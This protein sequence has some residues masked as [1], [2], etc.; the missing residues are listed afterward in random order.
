MNFNL[1]YE[2]FIGIIMMIIIIIALVKMVFGGG[3][4]GMNILVLIVSIS[5]IYALL[6]N[7][8]M[9]LPIGQGVIKFI[10]SFLGGLN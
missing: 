2:S 10:S 8:S 7:P 1:T 3:L 4:K 5:V 6:T 9:M